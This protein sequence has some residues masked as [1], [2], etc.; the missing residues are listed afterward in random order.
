MERSEWVI[1]CSVCRGTG[2]ERVDVRKSGGECYWY[3][4][5]CSWCDGKGYKED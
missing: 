3:Y 5:T 2:K 1:V 4:D